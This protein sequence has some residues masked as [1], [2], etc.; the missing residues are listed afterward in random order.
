MKIYIQNNGWTG[1]LVVAATSEEAARAMMALYEN[2]CDD[3]PVIE[4]DFV[5]GVINVNYGDL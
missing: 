3:K 4:K 5:E 2:Y 1:S